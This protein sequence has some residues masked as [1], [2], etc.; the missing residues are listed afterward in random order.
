VPAG[1]P[2]GLRP[3]ARDG[4]LL[5]TGTPTRAA[6]R[7]PGFGQ[8]FA[9]AG[10]GPRD[11][12]KRT[13]GSVSARA[14]TSARVA[15]CQGLT[16]AQA[17]HPDLQRFTFGLSAVVDSAIRDPVCGVLAPTR[18]TLATPVP[19]LVLVVRLAANIPSVGTGITHRVAAALLLLI[20]Y[21]EPQQLLTAFWFGPIDWTQ[22]A[23]RGRRGLLRPRGMARMAAAGPGCRRVG[24]Q[25]RLGQHRRSPVQPPADG[26]PCGHVAAGFVPAG[27]IG[28]GLLCLGLGAI[29]LAGNPGSW[30]LVDGAIGIASAAAWR[31]SRWPRAHHGRSCSAPGP[32]R[33]HHA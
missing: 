8:N 32:R 14:A 29:T 15:R 6:A 26:S 18:A 9:P 25:L 30:G 20:T 22:R 23:C 24:A 28:R 31:T 3:A 4:G 19:R 2:N 7:D 11:L 21:P 27:S 12:T 1:G 13:H 17:L 33:H 10:Q 5:V 16:W